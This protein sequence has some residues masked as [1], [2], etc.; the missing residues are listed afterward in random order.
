M[1]P[2]ALI[3]RLVRHS[4]R[5]GDVV[6][7]TFAGSGSTL[8]VCEQLNRINYSIELDPKYVHRILNRFERE[9]GIKPKQIF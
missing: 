2:L 3:E 8:M 5:Q 7:D 1:K 9:T 4:S 6:L